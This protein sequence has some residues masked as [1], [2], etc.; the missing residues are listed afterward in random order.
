MDKNRKHIFYVLDWERKDRFTAG[1]DSKTGTR[2]CEG[3]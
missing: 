1:Q 2:I 3:K